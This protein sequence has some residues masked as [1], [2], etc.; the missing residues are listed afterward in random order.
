MPAYLQH[1]GTAV[2]EHDIHAPFTALARTLLRGERDQLLFARMAER[3]GISHRYSVLR[4]GRLMAG[5]I[6]ADG[7]YRRGEFP[8]TAQRMTRF[9]QEAP[10]LALRAVRSMVGPADAPSVARDRLLDGVTHLIL[11][12][13]TGFV[14]PGLDVQLVDALGLR[15]DVQRTVI[16]FMGCAAALPALRT[17][18]QTVLADPSARVLVVN[19]E[20]CSLHLHESHALEAL[21]TFLLFGDA[22]SA[23]LVGSKPV[24]AELLDFRSQLLPDSRDMITWHIGDSGFLMHLSGQVPGRISEALKTERERRDDASLLRGLAPEAYALW[25]VHAGGRTVLDA[26]QTGLGLPSTALST[27]RA[28]LQAVG[29]VSSTTVMFV[30]QRML[31][32]ARPDALGQALAFGPG[33]SAEAMRFRIV[34]AA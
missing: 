11:A 33:L 16:G 17:A 15:S 13:C 34:G 22:A 10:R 21:L 24:G 1:I 28:V 14:A 32:E 6:D 8:G 27:S 2:P 5:E 9:E 19:V 29:N 30:L 23:A 26:V 25:A 3:L 7:F 4:P 20:L 18:R 31:N 12:T